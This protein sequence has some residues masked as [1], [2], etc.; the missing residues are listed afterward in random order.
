MYRALTPV[1]HPLSAR[2]A[3]IAGACSDPHDP[4]RPP[5]EPL[6]FDW[7][8]SAHAE[9][10]GLKLLQTMM[11]PAVLGAYILA[12]FQWCRRRKHGERFIP[13]IYFYIRQAWGIGIV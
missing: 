2:S 7:R 13:L 12:G 9:E 11:D 4:A 6:F 3:L 5:E 10:V 8:T 1:V